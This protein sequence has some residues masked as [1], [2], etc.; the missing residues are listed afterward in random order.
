MLRKRYGAARYYTPGQV[1][2]A[3]DQAGI[4]AQYL[5]YAYALFLSKDQFASLGLETPQSRDYEDL[6]NEIED[7]GSGTYH[8]HS[9]GGGYLGGFGG[10]GFGDGGSGH[11]GGDGGGGGGGDGC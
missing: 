1:K 6:R 11:G 10:G 8:H 5:V 4:E 3:S 2:T 9:H 7:I